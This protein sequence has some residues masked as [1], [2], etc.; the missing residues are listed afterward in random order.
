MIVADQERERAGLADRSPHRDVGR[1][2]QL[3]DAERIA[4]RDL[5]VAGLDRTLDRQAA[6]LDRHRIAVGVLRLADADRG[7]AGIVEHLQRGQPRQLRPLVRLRR[8]EIERLGAER[9]V[10]ARLLPVG[11]LLEH[12]VADLAEQEIELEPRLLDVLEQGLGVGAVRPGAVDRDVA[13]PGR[14]RDHR[15]AR[16]VVHARETV[17]DQPGTDRAQDPAQ[18]LCERIVAAGVD[19]HEA[20]L[21]RLRDLAHHEVERQGLVEQVALAL[22]GGIDRQQVIL[23]GDLD[24]V[25]GVEDDRRVGPFGLEAEVPER[26][27]HAELIEIGLEVD[28][29]VGV[30]QRVRDRGRIVA[31]VGQLVSVL[32]GRVADHQRHPLGRRRAGDVADAE[33][34][35]DQADQN[36]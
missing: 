27:L 28:L 3:R 5:P 11:G 23:A 33:A 9:I 15:V 17:A 26:V 1:A 25:A 32:I 31:R 16:Q 30:T 35:H 7:R 10:G 18:L 8:D 2:G 21:L 13:R 20:E 12:R 19:D 6:D 14:E 34:Q 36:W 4:D 29:E 24:A 22:E